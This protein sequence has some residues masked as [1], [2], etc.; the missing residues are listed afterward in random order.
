M[1]A[2]H[3]RIL[4]RRITFASIILLA[5]SQCLGN[6]PDEDA[7]DRAASDLVPGDAGSQGLVD[8]VHN[9]SLPTVGDQTLS[10][11]NDPSVQLEVICFLGTE[12]PLARVYGPRLQRMSGE[13]ADRGVRF[14]GINSNV[15]DSMDELKDYA[16]QHGITFPMAKDYDRQVAMQCGATR[17]PEVLVVDRSGAIRYQGRIDDQYQPGIARSEATHH[18]LRNAIDQLLAGEK[19][20]QPR[21]QAVGCLIALPR[22]PMKTLAAQPKVTFCDQVIRV[23]QKHC[24]ECHREGEIG[25][26]ALED[27]DEVVGWADMSLEVIDEGRMPPWHA[28]PDHGSFANA[29]HMSQEE[30]ETLRRWVDM[31]MPYGDA[32]SLPPQPTYVE[33]WRL[34]RTPDA[35]FEMGNEPFPVP[36]EGTVEYQ[37]FVVNPQFTEDKWI[38][39]AQ[40]V[41]GDSSVVHHCIVFVRPPDGSDFQDIGFLTAY[42][43]G[44]KQGELPTGYA[45]RVPAGSRLVFQMHYTPNGR[46][47]EDKTRLGLVFTDR[48]NVTHQVMVLGGLDQDFEIPPHAERYDVN[49]QIDGFPENGFLLSITPHMHLRGKSFE[50]RLESADDVTKLLDVPAYDFNWQ[51]NYELTSPLPLRQIEKLSFTAT[52]DNS[53]SNPTNPNPNEYVTWGDQTWQEMAVTFISVAKPLDAKPTA[54]SKRR[55][56]AMKRQREAQRA[57]W[58]AEA[59][60]FADQYIA[61]FDANGDQSLTSHELPDSVRMFSFRRFDLNSDGRLTH[62]EILEKAY[63]RLQRSKSR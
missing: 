27:Y 25:P 55:Q 57:S 61:R 48:E 13:Y 37:Y 59:S 53:D 38:R 21:T 62:D 8:R 52:F 33:G 18:D 40:V 32:K 22:S 5:I 7:A 4:R 36:A 17:T 42:V 43:P 9:F 28:S 51:H 11:S 35:V 44:Q 19:V 45:Q 34:P 47:A 54:D 24:V 14:I 46:P 29:R 26:F 30:K 58:F 39:A 16:A 3:R 6:Q 60:A 41:P 20:S 31:G 2:L 56:Q 15:Q 12:C 1:M 63:E 10:R 49:G 50:F 23:L